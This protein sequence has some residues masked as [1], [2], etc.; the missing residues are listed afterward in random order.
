MANTFILIASNVLASTT[1]TIT[2]SSIPATYT[3]LI[4]RMSYRTNTGSTLISGSLRL[5]GLSTTVY[6]TVRMFQDG[7]TLGTA[8]DGSD[9]R[10]LLFSA[11]TGNTATTNAFGNTE[12]YIPAY[13]SASNKPHSAN[14]SAEI[15][16]PNT[17]IGQSAH[18]LRDTSAITSISFTAN[19]P[20]DLFQIGSSFYLYGIKN[21]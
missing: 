1:T 4:L 6:S 14:E 8:R 11:G 15:D 9:N 5:N 17:N 2:F 12:V 19:T 21:S 13:L 18:L 16:S 3:D 20:T 7:A 10:T